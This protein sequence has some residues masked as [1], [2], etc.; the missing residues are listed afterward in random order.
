MPQFIA[1]ISKLV[2]ARDSR[3]IGIQ[4]GLETGFCELIRKY[5]PLKVKPYSPD[6]WQE[7]IYNG[8]RIFNENYWFQAYTLI[9]GLSGGER[10][11]SIETIRLIDRME[12]GLRKE[13]GDRAHFTV[14]PLSF[15]PL[16]VLKR[17]GFFNIDDGMDE[18]RFWVI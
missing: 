2:R 4:S 15:V 13:I 5:M 8:T 7:V 6:E 1:D 17:E 9:V 3:H 14:T 18:A 11:D 16:A 10:E 12:S